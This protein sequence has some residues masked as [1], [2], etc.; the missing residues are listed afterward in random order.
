MLKH[1]RV[2]IIGAGPAGSACAIAL[3]KQGIDVALVDAGKPKKY[4]IG[5]SIPPGMNLLLKEL[6]IY[7]AFLEDKHEP[8]YGSCSYWGSHLRGYNDFIISPHGHGWHLDRVKFNAFMAEQAEARG[9]NLFHSHQYLSSQKENDT[10]FLQL[11]SPNGD[12]KQLQAKVVIDATG[13]KAIFAQEQGS[14]KVHL[15]GLT[16]LAMRYRLNSDREAAHLSYLE[17]MPLGWWYAT[18]IPNQEMLVSLYSDSETIKHY[19]LHQPEVWNALLEK[20]RS[21]NDVLGDAEPLSEKRMGF[22]AETYYLDRMCGENWLAIGDAATTYDPIMAN[23]ITKAVKHGVNS[24]YAIYE[25]LINGRESF[26]SFE[27]EMKKEFWD[28]QEERARFYQSEKR[29]SALHFWK[30]M[31]N[32]SEVKSPEPE[33]VQGLREL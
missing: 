2:V 18:R 29:W 24:A 10:Y 3:Q 19:N 26:I 23:G 6:D 32:S 25:F 8:C 27:E 30:E 15:R 14:K 21:I 16:C 22:Q 13:T 11:R 12:D 33:T 17:S 5:E 1:Y 20:T 28:Y 7:S 31:H 9:V 4:H